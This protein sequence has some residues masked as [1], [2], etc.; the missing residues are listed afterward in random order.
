MKIWEFTEK[1]HMAISATGGDGTTVTDICRVTHM[2][3]NAV[4]VEITRLVEDGRIVVDGVG[5]RTR[6]EDE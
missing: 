1:V 2:T 5:V 6:D 4:E 3:A